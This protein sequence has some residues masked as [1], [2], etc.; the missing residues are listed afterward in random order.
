MR[1]LFV[2][3]QFGIAGDMLLASLVDLGADVTYIEEQLRLLPLDTFKMSFDSR[4]E[5]GIQ[6]KHLVLTFD[7]PQVAHHPEDY[8]VLSTPSAKSFHVHFG[9]SHHL[10]GHTHHSHEHDNH[11]HAHDHTHHH[12]HPHDHAHHHAGEILQMIANSSLT[13]FVKEKSTA[14]FQEIARAEGKIHGVSPE[15]VHF[16]E[17]GAMDSIIDIIG[18]CIALENLN[19]GNMT[20]SPVATGYGTI[21]IAHGT[22][23]V[24]APATAEILVGVPL[25]DFACRGELTTPTGAAFAKVLAT[26]YQSA[27]TGRIQAVGYGIGTKQ[28]AHPNVL[29]TVLLESDAQHDTVA[30]LE[31]QIDDMT[32]E[33]LGYAFQQLMQQEGVLDVYFTPISMKKYRPATLLTVLTQIGYASQVERYLLRHTSTFGVRTRTSGRTIL[34]REFVEVATKWG[35]VTVKIGKLDGEIVKA[36]PEYD[37][38]AAIAGREQLAFDEVYRTVLSHYHH[39]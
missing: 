20:F 19:V 39:R 35:N 13:P 8:H 32:G 9:G 2:D 12:S 33:M 15:K 3:C 4:N 24:P 27:A 26:N 10:H 31:C 17:V 16:H 37:E 29:R 14:I 23:P 5:K 34:E 21:K 11:S 28:F 38:V 22:Y 18:V 7:T 25:S 1:H 6:G 36:T 30:V